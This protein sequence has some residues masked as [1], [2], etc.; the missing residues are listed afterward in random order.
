[1]L[2]LLI[3]FF[4]LGIVLQLVGESYWIPVAYGDK[5]KNNAL[6]TM[7][8]ASTVVGAIIMSIPWWGVIFGLVNATK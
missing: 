5:P 6:L 7:A 2:L 8:I 3:G 1:V 4:V